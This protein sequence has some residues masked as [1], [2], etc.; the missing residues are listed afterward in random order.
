MEVVLLYQRFNHHNFVQILHAEYNRIRILTNSSLR[1]YTSLKYLYLQENFINKIEE[2]AFSELDE[3]EVLDLT[4]NGVLVM[5]ST[6]PLSLRKLSLT[7]NIGLQN[8]SLSAAFNLN[9]L[10]LALCDL[11]HLPPLGT[12]PNLKVCLIYSCG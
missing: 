2:G 8:M 9:Y 6:L 3:L 5:P 1:D 10:S 7:R 11:K 12:L 4:W